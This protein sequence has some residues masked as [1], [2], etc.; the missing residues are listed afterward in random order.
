MYSRNGRISVWNF[1][2]W[3][4]AARD[5]VKNPEKRAKSKRFGVQ[6]IV[7]AVGTALTAL[8]MLLIKAG[9]GELLS[10]CLG[11]CGGVLSAFFF[12]AGLVSWFFQLYINRKAFTWISLLC[13][14]ASIA[15][16]ILVI[17]SF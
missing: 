13:I 15:S 2:D 16:P 6:T 7:Y 9:R 10:F 8:L 1:I 4:L 14:L 12:L 5:I 3:L 17:M 11:I